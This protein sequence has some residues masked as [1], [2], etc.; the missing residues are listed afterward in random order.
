M[1]LDQSW[2]SLPNITIIGDAAH[3][4]PP[5]AGEGVNMA[6]KDAL[7]LC[8]CLTSKLFPDLRSA[9]EHYEQQMLARASAVTQMT[10]KSTAMLHTDDSIS[11]LLKMFSGEEEGRG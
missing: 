9:I 6:M 1:P 8:E 3:V 5:Y 10:L 4:M 7:E 2:V 11:N